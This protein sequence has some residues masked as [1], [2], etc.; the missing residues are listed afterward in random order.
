MQRAA[1]Q[2]ALA[3]AR[4]GVPAPEV[5]GICGAKVASIECASATISLPSGESG[6][7]CE[8]GE[9]VFCAEMA[10][11]YSF[12]IFVSNSRLRALSAAPTEMPVK[13]FER[14]RPA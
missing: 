12:V 9:P 13:A 2:R 11:R 7:A 5:A 10:V 4:A 14:F 1:A 8:N 3:P 6:L